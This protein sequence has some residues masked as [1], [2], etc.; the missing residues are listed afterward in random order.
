ML[1]AVCRGSR[2]AAAISDL[3]TDLATDLGTRP[4]VRHKAIAITIEEELSITP[5]ALTSNFFA[6]RHGRVGRRRVLAG[7][8][9]EDRA[10][11]GA[12]RRGRRQHGA[13]AHGAGAL[14]EDCNL[15][16]VAAKGRYLLQPKRKCL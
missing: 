3:A 5:W 12:L 14:A 13:D 11:E 10:V 4:Q 1:H 16:G 9:L 7:A 2:D 8:A 15:G 6:H